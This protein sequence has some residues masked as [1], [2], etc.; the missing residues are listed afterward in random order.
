[1]IPAIANSTVPKTADAEPDFCLNLAIA[2]VVV[3]GTIKP[4]E[5]ITKN[6][7]ISTYIN[8]SPINPEIVNKMAKVSIAKNP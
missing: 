1:M 5:P 6:V 3:F 2:R 4:S 7:Q 8:P